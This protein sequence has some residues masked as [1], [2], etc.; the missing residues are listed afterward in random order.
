MIARAAA[1]LNTGDI[2]A[3]GAVLLVLVLSQLLAILDLAGDISA[4]AVLLALSSW[5][6]PTCPPNSRSWADSELPG[7]LLL[8]RRVVYSPSLNCGFTL[9]LVWVLVAFVRRW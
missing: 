5:H 7:R 1:D 4:A 8:S 2:S 6:G 9:L 3:D